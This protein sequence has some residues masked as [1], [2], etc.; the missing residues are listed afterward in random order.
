M[1]HE[2]WKEGS[3]VKMGQEGASAYSVFFMGEHAFR[4]R[5]VPLKEHC[6]L[7]CLEI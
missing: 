3:P 4:P 1:H 6:S 5:T 7:A 2:D